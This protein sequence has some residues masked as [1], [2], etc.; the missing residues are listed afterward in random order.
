[1]WAYSWALN[2]FIGAGGIQQAPSCH[3]MEHV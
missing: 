1:M 2:G 3:M